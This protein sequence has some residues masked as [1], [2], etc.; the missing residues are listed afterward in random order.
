MF[1]TNIPRR[2]VAEKLRE[3]EDKII[4]LQILI[5][6]E[7]NFKKH[8]KSFK[9]SLRDLKRQYKEL[10]SLLVMFLENQKHQN[11]ED[12]D[13]EL[14]YLLSHEKEVN[15]FLHSNQNLSNKFKTQ[16]QRLDEDL[17]KRSNLDSIKDGKN[18]YKELDKFNEELTQV[19]T[20]RRDK[21]E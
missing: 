4:D 13:N 8:H 18:L 7:E 16:L 1:M 11:A 12:F 17:E 10:K 3:L 21:M 2:K 9:N 6:S 19:I 15:H 14:K 20:I 5:Q